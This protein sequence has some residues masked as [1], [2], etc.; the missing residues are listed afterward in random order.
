VVGRFGNLE[1]AAG[2]RDCLAIGIELISRLE[3]VDDLLG[4]VASSFHGGVP[5]PVWPDEVSHSPWTDLQGTRHWRVIPEGLG[6]RG[7]LL[8][9]HRAQRSSHRALMRLG[10]PL[11]QVPGEM[12]SSHSRIFTLRSGQ[13]SIGFYTLQ[14]AAATTSRGC[15]R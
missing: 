13:L 5:G 15:W 10:Q 12:D 8:C 3:L 7:V 4:C 6:L 1:V 2:V 14:R 11:Q 9:E